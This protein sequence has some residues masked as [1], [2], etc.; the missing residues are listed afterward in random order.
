M[1]LFLLKSPSLVFGLLRKCRTG[2]LRLIFFSNPDSIQKA[3]EKSWG[4]EPAKQVLAVGRCGSQ[5]QKGL[6]Y[7][8]FRLSNGLF[9]PD[10]HC[11]KKVVKTVKDNKK[12]K[13]VIFKKKFLAELIGAE[14]KF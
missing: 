12:G 5:P 7:D 1:L 3:E 10:F 8:T 9:L 2:F 4:G 14:F 6:K 13:E 11:Q